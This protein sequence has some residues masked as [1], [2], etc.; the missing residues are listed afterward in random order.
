MV[1]KTSNVES[2][3]TIKGEN[4]VLRK[5]NLSLKREIGGYKRA[6]ENYRLKIDDLN[7]Q[8][9]DLQSKPNNTAPLTKVAELEQTIDSKNALIES[10]KEK[11]QNLMVTKSELENKVSANEATLKECENTIMDLRK[12][13]WKR[14]F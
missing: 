3:L 13:W 7:K 4:E 10:M 2:I 1:K 9:H 6:N 12:P 5:E 11:I 8:I 14:L